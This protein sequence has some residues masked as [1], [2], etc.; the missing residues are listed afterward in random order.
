[1]ICR[2]LSM[3]FKL[4]S[5]AAAFSRSD[6]IKSCASPSALASSVSPGGSLPARVDVAS[7]CEGALV[8]AGEGF[9]RLERRVVPISPW[10]I[11]NGT[12]GHASSEVRGDA[13]SKRFALLAFSYPLF[14]FTLFDA[15]RERAWRVRRMRSRA[16]VSKRDLR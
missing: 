7:P 8:S 6:A 5:C 11:A 15:R 3:S 16:R 14:V 2:L 4:R 13:C 1:M 10:P 9:W 12:A